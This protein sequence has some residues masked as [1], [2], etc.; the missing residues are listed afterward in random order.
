[1]GCCARYLYIETLVQFDAQACLSNLI[2]NFSIKNK[3]EVQ[4]N[5]LSGLPISKKTK[6]KTEQQQA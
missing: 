6:V 1:V 2:Q 4:Q 3:E 5:M